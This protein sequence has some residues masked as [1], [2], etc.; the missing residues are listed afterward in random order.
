MPEPI[1]YKK[2]LI[3]VIKGYL[4]EE[5]PG[6]YFTGVYYGDPLD[7]PSSMLPCVAIEKLRTQIVA[8]P[9]GMDR[10][11]T[12]VSIKL[13]YNKKD[14]FGKTTDEVLGVRAL[15]EYAEAINPDTNQYDS[16]SIMGILRKN[17]TL[18][19][20]ATGRYEVLNQDVDIKYGVVPRPGNGMTAEC[21]IN[22]TFSQL[23]EVSIR[24]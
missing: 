15:E 20:P 13:L 24:R 22:V 18:S 9:T 5:L 7:I 3:D 10:V 14:D 12:T 19:D 17:F 23:R 6:G 4:Q 16:L 21:Q 1:Q 8:G 11:T 2:T